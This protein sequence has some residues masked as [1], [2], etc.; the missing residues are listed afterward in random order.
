MRDDARVESLCC[1]SKYRKLFGLPRVLPAATGSTTALGPWYANVLN[2]RSA[3]LLHYMSSTSR[4]SVVIWQKE[5]RTAEQR[6][7]QGLERLLVDLGVPANLIEAELAAL[8]SLQ[9]ARA[10]DRSVLGSMRDQAYSAPYHFDGTTTPAELTRILAVTPCGP[11]DYQSPEKLAPRL[12]EARWSR[13][14]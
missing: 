9:Y 6:F 4:L 10:T 14:S 11:I 2:F 1:T 12:I 7:I 8:S 5:R 3:R 13:R